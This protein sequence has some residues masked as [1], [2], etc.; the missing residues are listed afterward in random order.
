MVLPALDEATGAAG[1]FFIVVLGM[2]LS[3]EIIYASFSP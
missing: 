1:A 3:I 2:Y